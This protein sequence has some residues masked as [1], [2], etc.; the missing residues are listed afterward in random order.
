M[1]LDT[2]L[3]KA[4]YTGDGIWKDPVVPFRIFAED[5]LLVQREDKNPASATYGQLTDLVR[6]VDY[7]VEINVAGD[8]GFVHLTVAPTILQG[9]LI[10]SASIIEQQRS[11]GGGGAFPSKSHEAALDKLTRITQE[12]SMRLGMSLRFPDQD[13]DGLSTVLPPVAQRANKFLCFTPTGALT[14]GDPDG[15]VPA[16]E[17]ARDAAIAASTDAG[18]AQF[19][20]EVAQDAAEAAVASIPTDVQAQIDDKVSKGLFAAAWDVIVGASTAG[21]VVKKTFTEFWAYLTSFGVGAWTKQQYAAPIVW[22]AVSGAMGLNADNHQDLEIN[23]NGNVTMSAPTSPAKGKTLFLT[24]YAASALT[25]TWNG[26]FKPNADVSL[27]TVFVAGKRIFMQ[28]RCYDG[29]NWI[30]LGRTQEA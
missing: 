22:S 29:T 4:S 3:P 19:A 23:A 17:A 28:F 27:D 13:P 14:A 26:V 15:I 2:T 5:E 7:T 10:T 20:A 25:I 1:T 12:L 21:T 11:Y 6:G 16:A 18:L 8:G 24:L 9:I 30:L